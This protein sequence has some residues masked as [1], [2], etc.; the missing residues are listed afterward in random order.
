MKTVESSASQIKELL[1]H[2]R[3]VLLT[4]HGQGS[5]D[6]LA[7][8]L[9]LADSIKTFGREVIITS[10]NPVDT[11]AN[12]AGAD[13]FSQALASKSLTISL[14]YQPGSIEKVSYGT[15]GNKFNLVITPSKGH[16]FSPENVNYA[17]SGSDYDLVFVLD[18]ADLALLG[19]I[20]ESEGETWQRLPVINIDRHSA[21]TQ[22]GK[23]N[24]LDPEASSTSEIVARLISAAKLPL[25]KDGAELLLRGIKE[26]TGNFGN[27]GPGSFER[28]A[29]L[30]RI[31]RG[32]TRTES[33]E[34]RLVNEPFRKGE[35]LKGATGA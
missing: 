25:T 5:L 24:V 10:A 31:I 19:S 11:A 15:E 1:Q 3:R 33:T 6:G 26:A 35:H 34:E 8:T 17:Y 32:E 29:D 4:T 28:A 23:V 20:Y 12:L 21:N 7:A 27:A 13:K 22:Y 14:D 18:T 2:A 16:N 9:G 30:S